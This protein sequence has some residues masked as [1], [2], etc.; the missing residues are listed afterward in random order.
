MASSILHRYGDDSDLRSESDLPLLLRELDDRP[1]DT[2][3]GSVS[4][5]NESGWCISASRGGYVIFE[6]LEDGGER[7]M[8]G[9]SE[10]K[11]I[12][13]WSRLAAGDLAAI[14]QE[15]WRPGYQ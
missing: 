13:L 8:Q 14:E 7:H 3:H 6:H 11:I 12:E 9:V 10:P 1:E 4:V 15:P 5:T 2:D